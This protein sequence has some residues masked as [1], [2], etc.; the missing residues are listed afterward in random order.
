ML[1]TIIELIE[2]LGEDNN[3]KLVASLQSLYTLNLISYPRTHD[4]TITKKDLESL[5]RLLNIQNS[6][7]SPDSV[8]KSIFL[9]PLRPLQI[10]RTSINMSQIETF[11]YE[12][13]TES[14][15]AWLMGKDLSDLRNQS[16]DIKTFKE[17][18]K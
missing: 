6:R 14:N 3:K 10:P 9:C 15:I 12:L 4:R 7:I 11:L 17:L 5:E 16:N 18:T 1:Y 13:I 2:Y 8:F